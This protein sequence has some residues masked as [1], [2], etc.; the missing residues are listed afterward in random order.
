MQ[1]C[2]GNSQERKEEHY[3]VHK[4]NTTLYVYYTGIKLFLEKEEGRVIWRKEHL[5]RNCKSCTNNLWPLPSFLEGAEQRQD[6]APKMMMKKNQ[7]LCM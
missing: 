6:T 5:R 2:W 3:I 4:I 7:P 1:P